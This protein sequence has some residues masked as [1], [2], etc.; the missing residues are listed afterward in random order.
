LAAR[1]QVFRYKA[2]IKKVMIKCESPSNNSYREGVFNDAFIKRKEP[3]K[4]NYNQREHE[5]P[6]IPA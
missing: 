3:D 4:K 5:N 6:L 1:L 2:G